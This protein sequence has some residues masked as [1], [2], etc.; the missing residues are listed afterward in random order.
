MRK[1]TTFFVI[2]AF[3]LPA[4][5]AGA[6]GNEATISNFS[7][8]PSPVRISVGATLKWTNLD[9]S[10]HTV[11]ADDGS[12]TSTSLNKDGTFSHTFNQPGT[13]RYHCAIH[14]SMTGTVEVETATAT[15]AAPTTTT[16]V[17]P[18]TST[19]QPTTTTAAPVVSPT[20]GNPKPAATS[21]TRPTAAPTTATTAQAATTTTAP[22]PAAAPED[23]TATTEAAVSPAA[24]HDGDSSAGRLA[25][26]ATAL[27]LI[28]GAAGW[29]A[30]R[31]RRPATG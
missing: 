24:S 12:W 7:F 17:A 10:A 31:H 6:A 5:P 30:L 15:T 3:L 11:T 13:V 22:L 28:G 19:S 2:L 20:T 25:V 1:T 16:T 4:A 29:W 9:S 26:G 21:T 23:T 27:L 18:V 8:S 14:D